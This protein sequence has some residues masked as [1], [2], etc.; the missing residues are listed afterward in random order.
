[1]ITKQEIIDAIIEDDMVSILNDTGYG[2]VVYDMLYNGWIGYKKMK[3][4][5]L[6]EIYNLRELQ[7]EIG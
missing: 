4:S 5:K 7:P 1:M 2:D 6:I 3:K